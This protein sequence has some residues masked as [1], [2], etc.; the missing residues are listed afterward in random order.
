MAAG[1]PVVASAVGGLKDLVVDGETGLLVPP[2]DVQALREALRRLLDD[3]GLRERLGQAARE[4]A[5][6][7]LSWDRYVAS[8][9]TAYDEALK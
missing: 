7:H 6:E 2:G 8:M 9:R 5:R 1:R 4:R 3:R